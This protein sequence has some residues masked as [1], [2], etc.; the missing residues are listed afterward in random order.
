MKKLLTASAIITL[1]LAASC[2]CDRKPPMPPH[3]GK[4]AKIFFDK[5]DQDNNKVITKEEWGKDSERKFNELDANHDGEV[6]IDEF[7]SFHEKMK[8]KFK[9]P[10]PQEE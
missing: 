3:Q 1:C 9:E 10:K 2:T 5:L 7:K 4:M 6:T 8:E